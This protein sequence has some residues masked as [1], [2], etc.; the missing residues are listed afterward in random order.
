ML[1]HHR[2]LQI[3]YSYE[4]IG[5]GRGPGM[6]L[7]IAAPKNKGFSLIE[8]MISLVIIMISMLALNQMIVVSMNANLTNELR[9]AS[10]R[11]TNQTAEA[12]LA[13]PTTPDAAVDPLL[14]AGT[15][16]RIANDSHQ[17][18]VGLPKIRQTIRGSS[19]TFGINW[20]VAD[21]TSTVKQI[22]ITVSYPYKGQT[23]TNATNIFKHSTGM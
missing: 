14:S 11:L 2:S 19:T 6:L 17:D 4:P 5:Y 21:N 20:T 23:M 15:Y 22:Q 16:T 9:S 7:P 13:I 3:A 10:V 18:S 8:M 12:L 1:L